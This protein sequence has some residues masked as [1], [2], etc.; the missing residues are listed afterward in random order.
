MRYLLLLML[1]LLPAVASADPGYYAD[2][3]ENGEPSRWH[4]AVENS[5]AKQGRLAWKSLSV[6]LPRI[7]LMEAR[8]RELVAQGLQYRTEDRRVVSA[9]ATLAYDN[10][11]RVRKAA[12]GSLLS[13][14]T[15]EIAQILERLLPHSEEPAWRLERK[16]ESIRNRLAKQNDIPLPKP[17]PGP[18]AWGSAGLAIA[19]LL[20]SIAGLL[21]FLWGYRL[22]NLRR[23]L[24]NVSRARIRSVAM[25]TNG[26]RG[27][28]QPC[29]N[30]LLRHPVSGELC[31]YYVGADKKYPNHKFWL[32]D[33]SGRIL[34]DPVGALLL[35]EDGVLMPGEEVQL[36]GDVRRVDPRRHELVVAKRREPRHQLEV[37]FHFLLNSF[38]GALFRDSN[39]RALFS[40]PSRLFWIWNDLGSAPLTS[41][42]QAISLFSSVVAAGGWLVLVTI[43]CSLLLG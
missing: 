12:V 27:E 11:L 7:A 34:V 40:D 28:V 25:G 29:E 19:V 20:C 41:G 22:F 35:S 18:S 38:I 21:L 42:W 8:T 37:A 33:D 16:I 2:I 5:F 14:E 4:E 3:L 43:A 13:G 17:G 36:V 23:L 6:I 31:V 9:L 1:L 26:L 10:D 15:E 24:N 30:Q 39:S 32:V